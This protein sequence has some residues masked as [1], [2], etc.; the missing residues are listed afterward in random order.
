MWT[1][2]YCH[3][4]RKV[5]DAE[6]SDFEQNIQALHENLQMRKKEESGNRSLYWQ[7]MVSLWPAYGQL[8]EPFLTILEPPLP[9]S[10]SRAGV[11]V[12]FHTVCIRD[13]KNLVNLIFVTQLLMV[14]GGSYEEIDFFTFVCV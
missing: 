14:R 13:E 12:M 4:N 8:M 2:I 11:R 7:P 6:E 10:F 3:S 9:E 5:D 1:E